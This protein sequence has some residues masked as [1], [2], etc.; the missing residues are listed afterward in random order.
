MSQKEATEIISDKWAT[1][2]EQMEKRDAEM[3]DA[4]Q[5]ELNYLLVF[6]SSMLSQFVELRTYRTLNRQV[7]FPRSFP[8]S[9]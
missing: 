8:H 2:L 1:V 9:S 7:C 6:V 4:W 5:Y 3:V